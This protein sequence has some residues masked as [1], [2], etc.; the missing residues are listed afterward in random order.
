VAQTLTMLFVKPDLAST[1][2]SAPINQLVPH[3]K[4]ERQCERWQYYFQFT[5]A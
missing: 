5:G 3:E 2:P 4:P 1:D